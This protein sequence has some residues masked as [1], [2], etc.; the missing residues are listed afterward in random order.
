[1][2]RSVKIVLIVAVALFALVVVLTII[3]ALTATSGG[4]D[5]G[6]R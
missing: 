3:G 1:M 4:S 2:S 6:L 5:V